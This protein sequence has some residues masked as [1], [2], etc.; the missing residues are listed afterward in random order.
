M[1]LIIQKQVPS[2]MMTLV[3]T[4]TILEAKLLM[5]GTKTMTTVFKRMLKTVTSNWSSW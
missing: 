5:E 1:K 4:L 2:E 3:I